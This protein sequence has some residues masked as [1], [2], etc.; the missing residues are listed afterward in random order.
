MGEWTSL[1]YMFF[2]QAPHIKYID[3]HQA[4]VF[5]C[6]A[7]QCKGK[8][9]RD[10]HCHLEKGDRKSTSNLSKHAKIFWGANTVEIADE[11]CDV[12]TAH[13]VLSKTKLQDGS[14]IAEFTQIGKGKVTFSTHQLVLPMVQLGAMSC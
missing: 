1:I 10:V 8:N 7:G 13:K 9:G 3:D 12:D 4:Y 14:I 6:A 2:K 11:T 5:E